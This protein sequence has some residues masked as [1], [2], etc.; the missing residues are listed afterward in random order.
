MVAKKQ[1]AVLTAVYIGLIGLFFLYWGIH[2]ISP[3]FH[4]N[5][6]QG[7]DRAAEWLT[8]IGFAGA[9]AMSWAILRFRAVMGRKTIAFFA[10]LGLFMFVCAGEEISW[11]QRIFGFG[12]PEAMV[13]VN[14]QNE[15]NLHNLSFEHLHPK[16]IVSWFM[17][18][19]GIILPLVFLRRYI[20]GENEIFKFIPAPVCTPAFVIP[21]LINVF[22]DQ[23]AAFVARY[24]GPFTLP[25]VCPSVSVLIKRQ[26]EELIEMYWGLAIFMALLMIWAAWEQ[27]V[28]P[29]SAQ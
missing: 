27:S 20:R 14:E 28:R 25:P 16:D 17:K 26:C 1:I 9:A 7:E 29:A 22:E 4:M 23:L 19:Y 5:Y 2:R 12:T 3:E 18:I 15:F 10:L 8:F 21:E 13:E 24:F 11:G 6:M